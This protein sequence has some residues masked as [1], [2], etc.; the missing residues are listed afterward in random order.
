MSEYADEIIDKRTGRCITIV[1]ETLR[2]QQEVMIANFLYLNGI[3][4]T[5]EKIY[6]Y[7]IIG[8]NKPYT[9]DFTITQG[10]K[11]AYIEHFGLTEDERNNRY[12]K[13]QIEKYKKAVNDKVKLHRSHNTDLIYTFSAYNDGWIT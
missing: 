4:Y 3:E 12:T 1:H 5:Y 11:I 7:N 6:P 13:E 2:S 10:N 9:P 8:S